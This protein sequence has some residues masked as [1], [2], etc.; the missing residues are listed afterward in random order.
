[1]GLTDKQKHKMTKGLYQVLHNPKADTNL[2]GNAGP[3][4][5]ELIKPLREKGQQYDRTK[6]SRLLSALK[7]L[8]KVSNNVKAEVLP[9]K[10]RI[11]K[12]Y[13]TMLKTYNVSQKDSEAWIDKRDQDALVAWF[14]SY[15]FK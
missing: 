8:H 2:Y 4:L 3:S 12:A 9:I 10:M 13:N 5:K 6:N 7:G 11:T 14:D 15:P 1:M